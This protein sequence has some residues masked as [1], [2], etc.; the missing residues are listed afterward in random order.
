MILSVPP[1]SSSS[2]HPVSPVIL[3]KHGHLIQ[4]S[5]SGRMHKKLL[6]VSSP[7]PKPQEISSGQHSDVVVASITSRDIQLPHHQAAPAF[8]TTH[9]SIESNRQEA[10]YRFAGMV[11]NGVIKLYSHLSQLSGRGVFEILISVFRL[12]LM[13]P[14]LPPSPDDGCCDR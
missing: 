13:L 5:A 10:E 1:R 4:A 12:I 2:A 14:P 8:S 7:Y 11:R 3:L 6:L 9:K